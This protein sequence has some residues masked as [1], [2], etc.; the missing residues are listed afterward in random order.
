MKISQVSFPLVFDHNLFPIFIFDFP[1]YLVR[2]QYFIFSDWIMFLIWHIFLIRRGGGRSF[3]EITRLK[4]RRV[5]TVVLLS[6]EKLCIIGFDSLWEFWICNDDDMK[7]S[8]H[9]WII[10]KWP[11]FSS[12][13]VVNN[14]VCRLKNL[15]NYPRMS[16]TIIL[17]RSHVAQI[18][19]P[20]ARESSSVSSCVE[21]NIT[22][23]KPTSSLLRCWA[24]EKKFD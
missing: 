14:M 19:P 3:F 1:S 5:C 16:S 21:K 6:C 11:H 10:S 15:K 9:F 24:A 13:L 17:S 20:R 4:S 7:S 2:S 22:R 23:R 18:F 12:F 8:K